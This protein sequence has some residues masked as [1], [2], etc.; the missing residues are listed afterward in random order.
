VHVDGQLDLV[1]VFTIA[2]NEIAAIRVVR[3]PDKLVYIARQLD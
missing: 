1:Y 3:N 2:R